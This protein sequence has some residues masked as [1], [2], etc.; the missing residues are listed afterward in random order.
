MH[1]EKERFEKKQELLASYAQK[2]RERCPDF[3]VYSKKGEFEKAFHELCENMEIRLN[4]E[5][6][7]YFFDFGFQ[8]DTSIQNITP[9]YEMILTSGISELLYPVVPGVDEGA[10]AVSEKSGI[11]NESEIEEK[12]NQEEEQIKFCAA[13]NSVIQD[14]LLLSNRVR[15]ELELQK[16]EN[17][18]QKI[19]WFANMAD[20]PAKS[21]REALQRILFISYYGRREAH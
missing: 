15:E 6:F 10:V 21:F 1:T 7:V 11:E 5:S 13:Y 18:R 16:P 19:E 3:D 14:L 17:Y 2:R 8:F 12:D 9:N 20:R 4:Q